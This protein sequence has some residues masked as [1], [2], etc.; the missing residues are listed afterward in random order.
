MFKWIHLLNF[1]LL[2]LKRSQL[3]LSELITCSRNKMQAVFTAIMHILLNAFY[4]RL[5]FPCKKID[6]VRI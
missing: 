4:Q 1:V 2:L 3:L 6:F 5:G